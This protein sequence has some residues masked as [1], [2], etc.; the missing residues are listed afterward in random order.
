MRAETAF[1]SVGREGLIIRGRIGWTA[2]TRRAAQGSRDAL[3]DVSSS[4]SSSRSCGAGRLVPAA[5]AGTG[6]PGQAEGGTELAT[7][8]PVGLGWDIGL[9]EDWV[10]GE[11][12][13]VVVIVVELGEGRPFTT[14]SGGPRIVG[15]LL[16]S[17]VGFMAP[18]TC[19]TAR[20]WTVERTRDLNG[21]GHCGSMKRFS[22]LHQIKLKTVAH[23]R[24]FQTDRVPS[25]LTE[26]PL[27]SYRLHELMFCREKY[28]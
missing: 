2:A 28:K 17:G 5:C 3:G 24:A 4:S 6:A 21:I 9:M 15:S 14:R 13:R 22:T 23:C 20:A 25:G 7:V 11:E 10:K 18:T 16:L 8:A 19:A 12:S 27:A 26:L 1:S